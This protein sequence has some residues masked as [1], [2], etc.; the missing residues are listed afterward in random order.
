MA[1]DSASLLP[2]ALDQVDYIVHIHFDVDQELVQKAMVPPLGWNR[3]KW[4][5]HG[6]TFALLLG[7]DGRLCNFFKVV[8]RR[9][10]M[11]LRYIIG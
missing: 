1:L 9:V 11:G 4:P 5:L 6:C 8:E 3:Q 10:G 2:A 7:W